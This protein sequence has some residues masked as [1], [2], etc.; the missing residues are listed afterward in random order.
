MSA[1]IESSSLILAQLLF[2]VCYRRGGRCRRI[3]GKALKKNLC[4]HSR[5]THHTSSI[6]EAGLVAVCVCVC[7]CACDA[8]TPVHEADRKD[9]RGK[10]QNGGD[11]W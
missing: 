3:D 4:S 2:C 8:A 5:S 1:S 7:L 11:V 10:S 9:M 6:E